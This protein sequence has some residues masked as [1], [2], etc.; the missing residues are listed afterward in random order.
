MRYYHYSYRRECVRITG[1][2]LSY[3][4]MLEPGSSK[5]IKTD[6]GLSESKVIV[7]D[8]SICIDM[9]C[10]SRSLLRESRIRENIVYKICS[11]E[12]IPIERRVE[13]GYYKLF[14]VGSDKAPTLEINGIHM[15]RIQGTDP[16][17]DAR[18]KVA[19]ARVGWRHRVLDTCMGLG[20]TAINSMKRGAREVVTIEIDDVVLDISTE[21]PWSS[22]LEDYKITIIHGDATK[23]INEFDND[24]FDRIIHDPPRLTSSSGYLYSMKF[25]KEL[26]RVLRPGGILYHYTGDPGRTA[27][28]NIAGGVASR[29]KQVG[30]RVLRVSSS[31]GLVAFKPF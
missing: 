4:S 28:K 6:L 17:S 1:K 24:Y 18:Q 16:W 7:D 23:V 9:Y 21:N 19:L 30:F 3:I 29:L 10:V 8:K 5:I 13:R 15:H 25:Y 12:I 31:Q 14:P 11:D 22:W 26:W 27:L 20:Y 2:Q